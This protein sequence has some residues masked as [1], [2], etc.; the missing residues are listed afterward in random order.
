MIQAQLQQLFRRASARPG[1]AAFALFG[2]RHV[3]CT[4]STHGLANWRMD[5]AAVTWTDLQ[6]LCEDY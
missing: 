1:V 4:V 3:S 2:D 5:G 6:S